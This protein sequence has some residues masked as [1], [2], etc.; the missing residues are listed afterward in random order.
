MTAEA[1]VINRLDREPSMWTSVQMPFAF[2]LMCP[3]DYATDTSLRPKV[4]IK[5]W[6]LTREMASLN[7]A[8][9]DGSER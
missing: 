9:A 1:A 7:S 6:Y 3:V 4:T 2:L 8:Q 5:A